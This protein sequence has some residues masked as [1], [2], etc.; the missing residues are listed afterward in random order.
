M[1]SSNQVRRQAARA[2]MRFC[3]PVL[4]LTMAGISAVV[5]AVHV[6]FVPN[7]GQWHS[8]VKFQSNLKHMQVSVLE[9]H[10][11][12]YRL[13][14]QDQTLHEVTE[15]LLEADPTAQLIP[16]DPAATKVSYI[17]GQKPSVNQQGL[18]TYDEVRFQ[19]YQG[20]EVEYQ[21]DSEG[22]EKL[23]YVAPGADATKIRM[24]L[25]KAASIEVDSL[26]QL[27]VGVGSQ[28]ISFSAP[29]AWQKEGKKRVPI[30]VAW[31]INDDGSYGFKLAAYDRDEMLIID[32]VTNA[33]FFG[34]MMDESG[35]IQLAT[36]GD[37][38]L[39][40]STISTDIPSTTGGAQASSNIV[41]DGLG[42]FTRDLFIARFNADLTTLHQVTYY[43]GSD[44]EEFAGSVELDNG[45]LIIV[46][47]TE[48]SD[49]PNTGGGAQ[50]TFGGGGLLGG[51]DAF[52]IRINAS[53]TTI[54]NATYIG[55][56]DLD[57]PLSVLVNPAG[58]LVVSGTTGSSDFP[59]TAGGAQ[60]TNMGPA[61]L[62][63]EAFVIRV[64]ANLASFLQATYFGG[65][66]VYI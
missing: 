60:A 59:A 55:D 19:A 11:L 4:V 65:T 5:H 16:G 31:Q 28:H 39:S 2:L 8:S 63:S 45:D 34:G 46:G 51:G 14:D 41:P 10:S 57:N 23:F 24:Q 54:S 20:I 22:I 56:S 30:P 13:L 9:D 64:S 47:S 17:R 44:D 1:V 33:T 3:A 7:E 38:Y 37:V 42:G 61:F 25:D 48:S 49:L 18:P 62:D 32:P 50:T 66:S 26:G 15:R 29:F 52:A 53:L 58:E 12:R 27:R 36:S 6:P 40:G 21:L 43:G 35:G